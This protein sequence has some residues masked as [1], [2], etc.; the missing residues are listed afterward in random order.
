[1]NSTGLN[2]YGLI[3]PVLLLLVSA[4]DALNAQTINVRLSDKQYVSKKWDNSR[5]LPVNTVFSVL[6]DETGYLW[7]ATEEGLVRFDGINFRI[8]SQENVPGLVSPMFYD[9]KKASDGG[10]WAANAN[11]IVYAKN[12][13]VKV[14]N[15]RALVEGTWITTVSED[16]DGNVWAGTNDGNL[17][18][19]RNGSVQMQSGWDEFKNGA[20]IT[21]ET[22]SDGILIGTQNGL[23]KY[24]RET[25]EIKEFSEYRGLEVRAMAE[26]PGGNLW[27]GT[28][29]SG[30]F[31]H[32][33]ETVNN[34][35][36]SNGLASNRVNALQISDD[37]RVWA[38]LGYGGVQMIMTSEIISLSEIEFGLNEVNDIYIT[39]SGNVWLSAT[40]HGIIQM[41]PADIRMLREVDGLSNDITLAIY[42]DDEGVIWSGTAGAGMNRIENGEISRITVDHGLSDGVVL[43]IYGVDDFIYAATGNGLH[44]FNPETKRVDRHFTTENGLA[45]NIV[46]TIFLDSQERVWVG[47]RS[48]GIHRLHNH[49]EL[50]RVELPPEFEN[51]E[52]NSILEDSNGN[53]WFSTTSTGVLKIDR[54]DNS[55]GYSIHHGPS[56]EMVLSLYEDPEG[57]IWAGT[58]EGLLVLNDNGEF[59]LFNRSHGLQFNGIFRMIEDDYGYLWASGN[60]GIQRMRVENLLTVKNDES[61]TQRISSRLFDTS[62][63]MAN[64]EA[65]GG[66]FPAGWKMDNGQIWFPTMQGIAQINPEALFESE[67]GMGVHIESLRYG[68]NELTET[69]N[70]KVPPGVYNLE[71]HYGSFDFK[72]PHTINYFFRMDA[73]SDE[74]QPAGNRNVAYF[75]S[76]K[77]GNHTFEVKAEQFGSESNIAS[78]AFSVEPFFYQTVFFQFLVLFGLFLAGYFVHLFYSKIKLGESLKKLVD[79]QTNE[80]QVRNRKLETAL[81]DIENQNRVIKE[82]AWVQSH[83]FRGP[84]SRILGLIDVVENYDQFRH[85]KKDKS[86]LVSEIGKAAL[87]LDELIRK[88]N[89]EIEEIEKTEG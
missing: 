42:Q 58:N 68:D 6:K 33:G 67:E 78:I 21:I 69:D 37:G 44:R 15:A 55:T 61:G 80:L 29:T 18:I 34:I 38:G 24:I 60:F 83:Q 84:L 77:P 3:F 14:Y 71:I 81:L 62:D 25:G 73:L 70:I 47:T 5:G 57:S 43:G 56:S 49:L 22:I 1:M 32:L 10:V 11:T 52:F 88:L 45:S 76:L 26:A 9:L 64:H 65:N 86:E 50:E 20:V 23:F 17:L 40:G 7:A 41:I 72:K 36:E 53:I 13:S 8:Y 46:Q 31:H 28:R 87:E 30:I 79:H 85:I 27:V 19:L 75:T 59:R 51:A 2:I 39:K 35:N 16:H 63:G 74:W 82:V 12:S 89:A 54:D 4:T 66:V 48:G